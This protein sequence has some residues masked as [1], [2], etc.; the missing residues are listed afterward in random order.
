MKTFRNLFILFTGAA[1]VAGCGKTTEL[2]Y[3]GKPKETITLE[4]AHEMYKAYQA[5]FD[6]LTQLRQGKEDARYGW[7]S[8]DFYKDYIAYLEHEA[9]KVNIEVSGL[10][11]YFVAYP[12]DEKSGDHRDYMTYIFVP[13]YYD[14]ESKSHIAFDPLHIGKDGKPIPI[15]EIITK[16]SSLRDGVSMLVSVPPPALTESSVANMAQMCRPNCPAE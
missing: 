13:T 3:H 4:R 6:A 7:H 5:R 2:P 1:F 10:R 12:D 9:K 16:G 11:V 14:T 8:L 15:H